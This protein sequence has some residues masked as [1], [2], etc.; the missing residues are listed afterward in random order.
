MSYWNLENSKNSY[1][2]K[3]SSTNQIKN[4]NIRFLNKL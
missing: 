1:L 2:H 4:D 3:L